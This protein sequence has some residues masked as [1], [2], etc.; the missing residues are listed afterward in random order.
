MKQ[1]FLKK[2]S[3]L[4]F[5]VITGIAALLLFLSHTEK[6]IINHISN[7]LG[8]DLYIEDIGGNLFTHLSC[9]RIAGKRRDESQPVS[10]FEVRDVYIAYSLPHLVRGIDFFISSMRI[11]T[12]RLSAVVDVLPTD[13]AS[14]PEDEGSNI[15]LPR[16]LPDIRVDDFDITVNHQNYAVSVSDALLAV[17][18]PSGLSGQAVNIDIPRLQ[19]E[20]KGH[21]TYK[22]ACTLRLFYSGEALRID[23]VTIPDMLDS[24]SGTLHWAKGDQT[25][26]W[27]LEANL[28]SGE[29]QSSGSYASGQI[30]LDLLVD[31]I[32]LGAVARLFP[33]ADIPVSGR[34]SGNISSRFYTSHL[35]SLWA[36]IQLSLNDGELL[37]EKAD[38]QLQGEIKDGNASIEK[39]AANF[40]ANNVELE[41][42]TFPLSSFTAWELSVLGGVTMESISLHLQNIPG[43]LAAMGEKAN[44]SAV[45]EHTLDLQGSLGGGQVTIARGNFATQKNSIVIKDAHVRIPPAGRSFLDAPFAAAIHFQLDDMQEL[46]TLFNLPEAKGA[47]H[48]EA[49]ISGTWRAPVG[50]LVLNSTRLV[51]EQCQLGD[52]TVRAHADSSAVQVD[53]FVLQN[54]S[55]SLELSGRFLFGSK[56]FADIKGKFS[57]K[58]VGRYGSSCFAME[59]ELSGDLKAVLSTPEEGKFRLDLQMKDASFADFAVPELR[60]AV[61]T[62][63]HSYRIDEGHIR[64]G[65]GELRFNSLIVPDQ[66]NKKV[67]AQ[68]SGLTFTYHGADFSLDESS[69]AVHP[70]GS[71]ISLDMDGMLTLQGS[72][73][74]P[75]LA[76][77]ARIS[78]FSCPQLTLPVSGEME[79]GYER[80]KGFSANKFIL[81][82]SRNQRI[83]LHGNIPFDPLAENQFLV[84]PLQLTGNVS[85]PDF[86]SFVV[87]DSTEEALEGEFSGGFHLSGSFENPAGEIQFAGTNLF[88][89]HFINNAPLEPITVDGRIS[90][91]PHTLHLENI[92][93][94]SQ[95][96]SIMADGSWTD[97]P[98]IA[99]LL[100]QPPETLPGIVSFKGKV[101]IAD[102]SRFSSYMDGVRRI[103]GQVNSSFAV[104][105][106][107]A[108]PSFA[109]N[110]HLAKGTVKIANSTLPPIDS[111]NLRA[112]LDDNRI[113]LEELSGRIGGAPVQAAGS[114]RLMGSEDPAVDLNLKGSNI[115]LYRDDSMKIRADADLFLKGPVARLKLGGKVTLTDSRY[116]KNV[117]FLTM[118]RGSA[119]PK[120]ETGMQ[121]FSFEDPPLRDMILDIQ[122]AS[123]EPFSIV[124][125]MTRGSVR[126]ALRLTG[127]GE[128]PVIV[129][130]MYVDPTKIAV[131]AGK[132]LIE[133]GIVTFPENNPDR[134]T[135][136]LIA[137][138]RLAGYDITIHLQGNLEEP[139]I[140][141]SSDPPLADDELLLLVL[142]GSLPQSSQDANNMANMKMAVYLGKGLL[143]RWFGSASIEDEESVLER[144]DID[145]GREIS[146]TGQETVEAQF[147]LVEGLLL[148]GDLLYIISDKDVYDSYNVGMKIVFRFK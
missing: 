62:D 126:P 108:Q 88:L 87:K 47:G 119:K 146:K 90:I 18:Q 72:P 57:V 138:S 28:L 30:D 55:D 110:I 38:L 67:H 49:L 115:L 27:D 139:V 135:F 5:V 45:P 129:G 122:I 39:C 60:G 51:Y 26:A 73:D 6:I 74:L 114:F 10:D 68:F 82:T 7:Q 53:S 134:P 50:T 77:T 148:P 131:P 123:A 64:A 89:H 2:F 48:G 130:H 20:S 127:T 19:I 63:L 56:N 4:F 120:T 78:S 101:D 124:N 79:L 23:N 31:N 34:V 93:A 111:L 33:S 43:L 11:E 109:G 99:T 81:E 41:K 133:S 40:G 144:F 125:N 95:S 100:R 9:A 21:D 107:A 86:N 137:A 37:G 147:R 65:Q 91:R 69:A 3:F 118:F 14:L 66:E 142:T 8:L 59:E 104:N 58:D 96:I 32:T 132:I 1:L 85:L 17:E 140:T 15:I 97:I 13:Q 42:G 16:V 46:S 29:L 94:A 61:I 84:G 102:V 22:T 98:S 76:L 128:I 92:S 143:S 83:S 71:E 44:L 36:G 121:I 116:T 80:G 113:N 35:D 52:L 70:H 136:D 105:G 25:L 106:P 117:D 103:S 24:L 12:S 75:K 145:F 141:L 54:D 112:V